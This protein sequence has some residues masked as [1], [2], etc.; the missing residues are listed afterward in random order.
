MNIG[1]SKPSVCVD[2]NFDKLH[3]LIK[4]SISS[5]YSNLFQESF[6]KY[7]YGILI[8]S[9]V[10]MVISKSM[11]VY[12]S[13]Y[14]LDQV[15]LGLPTLFHLVFQISSKVYLLI[16]LFSYFLR[17]Q[18]LCFNLIISSLMLFSKL[19]GLLFANFLIEMLVHLFSFILVS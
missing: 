18:F 3:F 13:L 17:N 1:L 5:S 10:L 8:I 11:Y 15:S 9:S 14:L 16:L 19:F 2:V 6:V 12:F 4:L 7:S